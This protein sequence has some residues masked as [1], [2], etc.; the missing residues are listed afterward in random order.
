MFQLLDTDCRAVASKK[1][2]VL[3]GGGVFSTGQRARGVVW[4]LGWLEGGRGNWSLS[5]IET[6][7]SHEWQVRRSSRKV[8]EWMLQKGGVKRAKNGSDCR[9]RREYGGGE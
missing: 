9:G 2:E 4:L 5:R 1:E 7:R 3:D 6:F 8:N